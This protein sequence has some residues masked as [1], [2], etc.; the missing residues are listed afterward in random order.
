MN[1]AIITTKRITIIRPS[2][3]MMDEFLRKAIES[4]SC[5]Y[6]WVS[7]PKSEVDFRTYLDR[8]NLDDMECFFVKENENDSLIGV[9]NLSNIVRGFF[10]SAYIGFYRFK[11]HEKQGF[12]Q[13]ALMAIVNYAFYQLGIHRIEANVQPGN[14]KSEN[15]VKA[16][17]FV[18]EGYSKNYL[19]VNGEWRDHNR[20]AITKEELQNFYMEKANQKNQPWEADFSLTIDEV[21]DNIEKFIKIPIDSVKLYSE[22]W[23]NYVYLVN[24]SILCR[25]PRRYIAISLIEKEN[26]ILSLLQGKTNLTIPDPCYC[27]FGTSRYPYPIQGYKKIQG[28]PAEELALTEEERD[29]NIEAFAFFLKGLHGISISTLL[30]N[31]I[32]KQVFNRTNAKHMTMQ[33]KERV[34]KLTDENIISFNQEKIHQLVENALS[35]KLSSTD[36]CLVHGD[37]YCRH[38]LFKNST[39]YGVID[40]GDSGIN[41]YVVDL[42]AL[43]SFFPKK[44]HRKFYRIYGEVPEEVK[45]YAKFLGAYSAVA[46]LDYALNHGNKALEKESRF[47]LVMQRLI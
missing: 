15:L 31:D 9:F 36:R 2:I 7:P 40:W 24:D 17:G 19:K 28:E 46:C 21:K 22:G 23:D 16:S 4:Q 34:C 12:M 38:F 1:D 14:I 25:L 27:G 8:A 32:E 39:L 26:K 13:E 5:H 47:S 42:S 35:T 30:E 43:Y 20:F 44:A 29:L 3:K 37:L 18:K 41:H 6:P 10:Q 45:Y 11:G 33:F